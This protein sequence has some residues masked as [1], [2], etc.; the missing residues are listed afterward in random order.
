M[1]VSTSVVGTALVVSVG[2]WSQKKQIE[3]AQFVGIAVLAVG[4]TI[5]TD[6]NPD[7][8]SKF[9]TLIFAAALFYYMVPITK[10]LGWTK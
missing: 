5:L 9:S 2:R 8:G 3:V 4:L 1:Q 10:R 6:A 7:F